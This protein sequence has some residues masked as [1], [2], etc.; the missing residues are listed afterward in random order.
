MEKKPQ[1]HENDGPRI[2]DIRQSGAIAE[3]NDGVERPNADVGNS[4]PTDKPGKAR[5]DATKFFGSD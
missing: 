1:S 4:I 2:D 3:K 5:F